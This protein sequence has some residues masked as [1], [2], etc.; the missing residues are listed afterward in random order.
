ML[1]GCSRTFWRGNPDP[2]SDTTEHG[3]AA[4]QWA[5]R[6]GSY[7]CRVAGT[8]LSRSHGKVSHAQMIERMFGE[9][10]CANMM[11]WESNNGV[12]VCYSKRTA[13]RY[14]GENGLYISGVPD[15]VSGSPASS[16]STGALFSHTLTSL[17]YSGPKR[18]L[19]TLCTQVV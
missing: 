10:K 8:G 18:Y 17:S 12:N 13:S 11:Q 16:N 9:E 4:G 5:E 7:L 15:N 14:V 19:N 6:P 2:P 3:R 1:Y